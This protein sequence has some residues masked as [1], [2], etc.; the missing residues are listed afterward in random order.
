MIRGG[1][2][3]TDSD[4]TKN[5]VRVLVVDLSHE[6]GGAS[7]RA[8]GLMSRFPAGQI[9]LAAITD[10]PVYASAKTMGLTTYPVGV[11]KADWHILP[12][13]IKIIRE[14]PYQVI[15]TQ[16]IQSKLWGSLAAWRTGC[17]L[18]STLNSWYIFEHGKNPKGVIYTWLELVSNMHLDGYIV[19][20]ATV[21]DAL[22]KVVKNAPFVDLIYN[23]TG[24][25]AEDI[26]ADGKW[27]KTSYN[28]PV[29]SI[30]CSAVGRLV[31]AKGYEDLIE[32][33]S[34]IA[35]KEPKLHCLLI[36]D[37]ELR[38]PL[39]DKIEQA[40]LGGRILILGFQDHKTALSI[41]KASDFF[42][43][44]SR[45][46]GTPIALLEAAAVGSPILAT[47]CGGIPELVTDGEQ[48]ILVPPRNPS[49]LAEGLL[50]FCRD[51][52]LRQ[53]LASRAQ[54][55]IKREF[56]LETQV[57][58]TMAAYEKALEHRKAG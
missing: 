8:L 45:Q 37:G 52:E 55:R 56:S 31:W 35:G 54:A 16:N 6:F 41:M 51:S 1:N 26:H 17:A 4:S 39:H 49:A 9:G 12:N 58:A 40:G 3:V 14:H 33:M 15:D 24:V 5:P 2:G 25:Q 20:S 21:R 19:V 32:A 7:S 36:G 10:S 30:I 13:L 48:A 11:H 27:L 44:P 38:N 43:M 46:E 50:L 47:A 22:L 34:K 29:D 57:Q 18:V 42:V 28:L 23:A 53:V